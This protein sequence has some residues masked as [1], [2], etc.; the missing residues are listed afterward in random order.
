MFTN[1]NLENTKEQ[2]KTNKNQNPIT[3]AITTVNIWDHTI[4][5]HFHVT[6]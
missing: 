6:C 3:L 1:G 4:L 2:N 5:L